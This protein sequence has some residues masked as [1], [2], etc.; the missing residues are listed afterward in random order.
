MAGIFRHVRAARQPENT[1]SRSGTGI[2]GVILDELA[3]G[4]TVRMIAQRHGLPVDFVLCVVEQHAQDGDLDYMQLQSGSCTIGFCDPDPQS[5]VCVD[6]PVL[7]AA[8]RRRQSLIARITSL[9]I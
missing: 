1:P 9:G 5:L 8:A 4:S 6:C 2:A 7:P 3:S